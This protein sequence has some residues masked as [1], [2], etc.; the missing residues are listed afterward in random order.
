MSTARILD[1]SNSQLDELGQLKEEVKALHRVQAV[2]EFNLDGSILTANENFLKTVGYS[3]DEVQGK[4]HSMFCDPEYA[5]GIEY[6]NLWQTLAKGEYVEGEFKRFSKDGKELWIHG[7]YN[8]VFNVEGKAYKVIKFAVDITVHK[9]R[10]ADY[11]SR[12]N[13][14]DR[15]QAVIQFNLDGTILKANENFL[16]TIGYSLSEIEGKHHSMFCDAAFTTSPEY[17]EFWAKLSKGEFFAGD[18]RRVGKGGKEIWINASYNPIFDASGKV[19]KVVK[20]A[21]DITA[22]RMKSAEDEGKIAAISKAQAVI[23]FNLDG[24]ILTANENFLK[25]LGYSLSEIQGKHHRM[26]CDSDYTRTTEYDQFW[27]KLNRG[28]FDS[29]RYMRKGAGGRTVWIQAT[30]NPI[31]DASGKP[32]KVVKFASDITEQYMLEQSIKVKAEEDQKKVDQLLTV[33]SRAAAGDLTTEISVE[34]TDALGQLAEGISAMMRDLRGVIS[35]VVNSA[36]TFGTSSKS[37]ADQSNSVAGGAHSLGATVE[38]M[39]ASIEEFTASINSI[40]D[41]T[42]KANELAKVTHTEAETGSQSIKKSIE[43]MELINKSSED[44]SEIIKVISE[45]AS[46]TNLLAF[47]AAIEAARAGEHGLGFSVVADEVRKLAER[48]SQATKEISKLINESVKRV[49]QGSTIS[50][51]AGE[52]FNKILSGI[53]KTTQS[54]AEVNVAAEEQSEASKG[55]STAIQYIANEAMKSAQSSENIATETKSLVNNAEDLNKTVA[56]FVV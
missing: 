42:K 20:F 28:E 3:L 29:G 46:Q 25:T 45:I 10:H 6:R 43:A 2:I 5:R 4:H 51:Q 52:A 15:V 12:L 27:S 55:I 48:S 53:E 41:N 35:K 13:A 50:K 23:E 9:I 1:A 22:A 47:N 26:F 11:E 8:P 18:F 14:I 36:N 40:A 7:S 39:N 34:G 17:K 38:E 19:Y 24:T 49:E 54:I 33:V 31:M 30:Y 44:I 16:K 56:R 32:Y 37:I 21:T